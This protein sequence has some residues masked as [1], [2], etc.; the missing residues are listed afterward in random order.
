[1]S[2]LEITV[3]AAAAIGAVVGHV[4]SAI[5]KRITRFVQKTDNK[6]DDALW[7]IVQGAVEKV[8]DNY[9]VE[10]DEDLQVFSDVDDEVSDAF[11]IDED[12]TG[13]GKDS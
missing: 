8:L 3:F 2:E 5:S 1:M 9:A 11:A 6:L 10:V 12:A 4:L 7:N 13:D